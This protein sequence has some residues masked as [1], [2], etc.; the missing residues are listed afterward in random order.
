MRPLTLDISGFGTYCKSTHIDFS[1]FGSR[2]LYLIT[3][4]TGSG[5][6]TIF[7]AITYALYGVVNGSDRQVSMLRSTFADLETPTYVE[8]SFE[9]NGKTYHIKR[10]PKYERRAK[11]GDG[12]TIE[13]ADATLYMPDGSVITQESKVT[14][15]VTE[16]LRIDKNQFS[17]IVMIAQGEFRKLLMSDT[18]SRQE[19]FRKL[20]KTEYYETL[21]DRLAAE[22]SNLKGECDDKRK[23]IKQSVDNLVCDVDDVLS[24]ELNKAKEDSLP[25]E[26]TIA[27]ANKIIEQ[28]RAQKSSLEKQIDKNDKELEAINKTLGKAG[29]K[30]ELVEGRDQ[31][32]KDIDRLDK[33]L[34]TQ[35]Q[36]LAKHKELEP[37]LK[38]KEDALAVQ[39]QKLPQYDELDELEKAMNQTRESIKDNE[40]QETQVL[41]KLKILKKEKDTIAT[42]LKELADSDTKV[43]ELNSVM[44]KLEN[45]SK[46]VSVLHRQTQNLESLQ[47]CR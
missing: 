12:T 25:I 27:L 33:Q 30:Q 17:Q 42:S 43:V 34:K 7:D 45:R 16:L 24:L 3:G 21:Q 44:D 26:E 47:S 11:K 32:I 46:Q 36:A 23:S 40:G 15:A 6:T 5:K 31:L 1:K 9:Y 39:K 28:D 4:D 13:N 22:A 14:T 2:G 20:F 37:E 10:N 41:E 38:E 19:I 8:L 18:K 35:K 29:K